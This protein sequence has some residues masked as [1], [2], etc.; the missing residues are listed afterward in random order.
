[1]F[2]EAYIFLSC[3]NNIS[4]KLENLCDSFKLKCDSKDPITHEKYRSLGLEES[5]SSIT[6]RRNSKVN[7]ESWPART[8]M[9]TK[10]RNR[11]YNKYK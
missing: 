11:G 1:M 10:M 5:C 6:F 2:F 9:T 3:Q 7:L 4:L 8:M